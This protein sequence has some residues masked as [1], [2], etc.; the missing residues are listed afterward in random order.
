MPKA[1][2]PLCP[3][4]FHPQVRWPNR[5]KRCFRD[6][7]E[8]KSVKEL[9]GSTTSLNSLSNYDPATN[10]FSRRS[11]GDKNK[12]LYGSRDSM[13]S[14]SR[15]KSE[16]EGSGGLSRSRSDLSSDYLAKKEDE[17]KWSK[18]G[19][20]NKTKARSWSATD[21]RQ[22]V[23]EA[24]EQVRSS[25]E[26]LHRLY[27][28]TRSLAT[29]DLGSLSDLRGSSSD[30]TKKDG[31][32][33]N[34]TSFSSYLGMRTKSPGRPPMTRT[35]S[36]PDS[37]SVPTKVKKT[38][39]PTTKPTTNIIKPAT[40]TTTAKEENGTD[41]TSRSSLLSKL[42]TSTET[43]PSS[44]SSLLKENA[45]PPRPPAR[46]KEKM[47]SSKLGEINETTQLK[48]EKPK[49][50]IQSLREVQNDDDTADVSYVVSL[51]K[52]KQ[53]KVE[54]DLQPEI[55]RLN[56]ENKE[57]NK[58]LKE[59]KELNEKI[60]AENKELQ[61]VKKISR[62]GDIGKRTE[63]A[64]LQQKIDDLQDDIKT[65]NR[66]IKD[67]R[68]DIE[69]RPLPRDVDKTLEDLRSKL[70]AAEQ[71]CE[72]MMDENEDYKRE[73]RMLED[74]IEEMQD[75]FREEQADEY[76]D[77]KR[78]LEQTAKNCRVLQFK[79]KK[80]ERRVDSNKSSPAD[81]E[82]LA[83]KLKDMERD[84][85][86]VEEK[87]KELQV[88]D[89]D[90]ERAERIKILEKEVS[91]AKD[92]SM[93]MHEDMEKM[94]KNLEVAEKDRKQLKEKVAEKPPQKPGAKVSRSAMM[95]SIG[96]QGSQDTEEVLKRDLEATQ[97][98]EADLKDQ[99]KYAE[100]E[101]KSMRKKMTRVEEENET[102]SLQ[103]KK[104]SQKAK[105]Q[106]SLERTGSLERTSSVERGQLSRQGSTE[107]N[108]E[109]DEGISEDLDPTELK[110]QLELNEQET[111]VLRRKME[112]IESE[113]ERL[114]SE[115]RDLL[116]STDGKTKKV[117]TGDPIDNKK[118]A[119]E[120]EILRTK[121]EDLHKQNEKLLDENKKLELKSQKRLPLTG[122]ELNYI[123]KQT[124]EEKVKRLERK[125]KAE[126]E[127][128]K[129]AIVNSS[130]GQPVVEVKK[131][132]SMEVQNMKK[133]INE[134][135]STISDLTNKVQELE[136]KCKKVTKDFDDM[137][138]SSPYADRPIR[139]PKDTTPKSTLLKWVEELDNEC[140]HLH[141]AIKE[142]SEKAGRPM[143]QD[144]S[145]IRDF[146]D[147]LDREKERN[148]E[149][150]R[151]LKEER[152]KLESMEKDKGN[153]KMN[154]YDGDLKKLEDQIKDLQKQLG[155]EREK[156]QESQSKSI[157]FEELRQA[158]SDKHKAQKE[159]SEQQKNINVLE[160]KLREK[161][162]ATKLSTKT[163]KNLKGVIEQLESKL[164]EEKSNIKSMEERHKEMSMTW[165]KERDDI[166][167][168]L[169]DMK[170]DKDKIDRELKTSKRSADTMDSRLDEQQRKYDEAVYDKQ[171]QQEKAKDL[172]STNDNLNMQIEEMKTKMAKLEKKNEKLDSKYQKESE[173]LKTEK[174]TLEA[175]LTTIEN[176]L[177]AERKTRER[178]ER[179]ADQGIKAVGSVATYKAQATKA[180]AQ[181]DKLTIEIDSVKEENKK[182]M[183]DLEKKLKKETK[184]VVS[185]QK[186]YDLLEEDFV[187]QKAQFTTSSEGNTEIYDTLKTEHDSIQSELSALRETFNNRQ[188]TWIK[189]KLN[190]QDELKDLEERLSKASNDQNLSFEKK[191]LKDIIEDKNIQID[192]LKRDEETMKDQLSYY[193]RDADEL[194]RKVDDLE[195]LSALNERQKSTVNDT[196]TLDATIKDLKNKLSSSE[197]SSKMD[198]TKLKMKYDNKQKSLTEEVA[199]LQGHMTKYRRERDT[200]KE[201]LDG[202]QRTITELKGATPKVM[203]R[204]DNA[205]EASAHLARV[206]EFQATVTELEDKYADAKLE[207]TRAK[208]EQQDGKTTYEI[209]LSEMQSKIN[210][211][212]EDRLLGGG[213]RRVPGLRTR[214]E[215][216][217]QKEREEQQRLIQETATLAKDLRETLYEVER[218]R[219]IERLE[220]K[221]K[222]EQLKKTVGEDN[223][224]TRGKVQE[225]QRDLLDLR[226]AHAK[227][228]Q[229]NEKLRREKDRT[230]VER[231]AM[232][233][234]WIGSSREHLHQ[235]S[236][237]ELLMD[238]MK[239][240]KD[241][242]P[243]V[244]GE[245]I[246]GKEG[247]LTRL[248]GEAK[249]KTKEEFTTNLKNACKTME[250]MKR[251][252][253]L[254]DDRDRLKR[255][256]SF[257]RA[258]SVA[259]DSEDEG[260]PRRARSG[261]RG[262]LKG[263]K[264]P[265][266]QLYRKTQSLD[267]Q[268]AEERGKIWV[269]TDQ[270]S[271]S[272]IGSIDSTMTDPKLRD[273]SLDRISTGSQTS[274]VDPSG[275]KKKKVSKVKSAIGTATMKAMSVGMGGS[276]ESLPEKVE[277][278][279]SMK[280]R[281]KGLFKKGP[282]SRSQSMDRNEG[283]NVRS[284]AST[285]D[286]DAASVG[287]NLSIESSTS[288]TLPTSGRRFPRGRAG[289]GSWGKTQSMAAL[290]KQDSLETEV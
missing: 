12:D 1:S 183:K 108:K 252:L 155:E 277:S 205:T 188:D 45:K 101:T 147:K 3:L 189:E 165:L 114:Q 251:I 94:K 259:D 207:C 284:T 5:C 170:K 263:P 107:K 93:K 203:S 206:Q 149:L 151:Q 81:C 227:L 274:E 175:R 191:R 19:S 255:A 163:E 197:K 106:R 37:A 26:D 196:T 177:K 193:R 261:L 140:A 210:E 276:G 118:I 25:R 213:A 24:K 187:V 285:Y 208:N 156:V 283:P 128:L 265:K 33:P 278:Y 95:G 89:S 32:M 117:E 223:K 125:L 87:L 167:E 256:P 243:L 131:G 27:G 229:I 50:V 112:G 109:P 289:H 209:Q 280:G 84:K 83:K 282:P 58:H 120:V 158:Q 16:D 281:L 224:D 48:E 246:T 22:A 72:E 105:R 34:Y 51:G 7:T 162:E 220:A 8:H 43:K 20:W 239:A 260:S 67:L 4:G 55:D 57:L 65:K 21:L 218:E 76:R 202:A 139:K 198:I 164:E 132:P 253:N 98:R 40:T 225:L 100:E 182:A 64:K 29:N 161:E 290:G 116:N 80:T 11:D 46:L 126:S 103:L 279:S 85:S 41:H 268:M 236:K 269:S 119:K 200:F 152:R 174:N 232:R 186:K 2:D 44:T 212:E 96:R 79:L 115:I 222:V 176:E 168:E 14:S 180:E 138:N 73:I 104:M 74:E 244:L 82:D 214:L 90:A 169:K 258:L 23:D 36:V 70:T 185:L 195:K 199:E 228:R 173:S 181:V 136:E 113:N 47:T 179:D 144:L 121:T 257:R 49:K 66:E 143:S 231:E 59:M 271:T 102:L 166:K 184:E 60:E 77:L 52:K 235:Q 226:E 38:E 146:E 133:H 110:L 61:S 9:S 31:D 62:F 159:V 237:M 88:G 234:K 129:E 211:Y 78:E 248:S 124:L 42:S 127:K 272:S 35:Q 286:S 254:T 148:D 97:E 99:L 10:S 122:N 15:L 134:K 178:L 30:L 266:S 204:A 172:K 69:K 91:L 262:G 130:V 249:P 28:S 216:N 111:A 241:L 219:D 53:K 154:G 141:H 230:E 153:K 157:K 273:V 288:A 18:L 137:K 194:R 123:E 240:V 68:R 160:K 13:V 264:G 201:M 142:N 267:H 145:T 39:V 56:K 86:E 287:S 270:G 221:R 54:Y 92:V 247:S 171:Q 75:N 190:M 17:D 150:T 6:Y 275:E 242:A 250:E 215:L 233:D 135:D 71:L 217:W 192:Q 238:Q 63:S 245:D